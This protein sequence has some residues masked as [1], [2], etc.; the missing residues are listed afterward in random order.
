MTDAAEPHAAGPGAGRAE[1][2]ALARQR[3]LRRFIRRQ[4]LAATGVSAL[5]VP[6]VDLL[7]NG[8]LLAH[9]LERINQ[10]YG[11]APEQLARLPRPARTRVD[12]AIA[13][14]GSFLIGRVITQAAVLTAV[15]GLGLRLGAQQAA[16][17]AP[18]A[19][20]VA[21]AALS[22]WLFKRLCE[23]HMAQCELICLRLPELDAP[24]AGPVL[25]VEEEP[26]A[27]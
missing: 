7:L 13:E 12:A 11:L 26:P 21:S 18:I 27:R 8:R 20:L 10:Y 1:P 19:G 24:R 22:G 23:R 2:G 14:A 9:T 15:K 4:V 16:K 3:E 5:P 6:G 25:L 17:L